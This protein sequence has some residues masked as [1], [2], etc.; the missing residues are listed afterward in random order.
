MAA[1]GAFFAD[2]HELKEQAEGVRNLVGLAH[3]EAV[4]KPGVAVEAP[5]AP[6]LA[7]G[8]REFANLV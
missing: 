7:C 1:T 2:I 3:A 8:T 5:S 6:V 4:D